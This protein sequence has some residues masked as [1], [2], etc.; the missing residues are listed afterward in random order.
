MTFHF[1]LAALL[2]LRTTLE[3]VEERSLLRLRQDAR[4]FELDLERMV[5]R[6]REQRLRR[7]PALSG[8]ALLGADL[9]FSDFL[10]ARLEV[11]EEL[12]RQLLLAKQMEIQGQ[13][14]VFLEARRRREVME[15]LRDGELRSYREQERRREQRG[16]DDLFLLQLLH[17]RGGR[18][19]G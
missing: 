1:S 7:S 15:S 16:L 11:D 6:R 13:L 19:R 2:R 10:E 12:V 8:G 5:A 3:L 4:Q 17:T 9:Q 18:P 14:V